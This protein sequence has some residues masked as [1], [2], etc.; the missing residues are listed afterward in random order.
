MIS[1]LAVAFYFRSIILKNAILF[2]NSIITGFISVLRLALRVAIYDAWPSSLFDYYYGL[3]ITT[4]CRC[5]N[6]AELL[7]SP[8]ARQSLKS[9]AARI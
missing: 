6:A 4:T 1:F 9:A 3:S 2:G 5:Y 8:W 7:M